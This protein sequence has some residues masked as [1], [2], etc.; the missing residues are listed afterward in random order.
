[1]INI[2]FLED[3]LELLRDAKDM[4]EEIQA[5]H[6]IE[7]NTIACSNIYIANEALKRLPKID[8]IV[9]DLSMVTNGLDPKLIKETSKGFLTGWVWLQHQVL[10]KT[11]FDKTNIII[12]S[13]YSCFFSDE[14]C[15]E[16]DINNKYG[17]SGRVI[18][19]LSKTS[20]NSLE[21]TIVEL[22]K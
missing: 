7:L 18:K 9:T 21:E 5:K 14:I 22:I 10:N 6:N 19:L 20:Y 4:L 11:K 8:L 2:L 1:M 13:G 16:D 15:S 17:K 3:N 12:W